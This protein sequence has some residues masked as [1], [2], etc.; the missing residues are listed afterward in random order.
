MYVC[1]LLFVIEVEGT[2]APEGQPQEQQQQ[3]QEQSQA[4]STVSS[5]NGSR[6]LRGVQVMHF[7]PVQIMMSQGIPGQPGPSGDAA[8]GIGEGASGPGGGGAANRQA[9]PF[10]IPMLFGLPL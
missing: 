6:Q 3:P 10:G 9:P 5:G 1:L 4:T 8:G 2:D 7:P